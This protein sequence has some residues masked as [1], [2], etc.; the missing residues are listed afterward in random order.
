M[1]S[2]LNI[3]QDLHSNFALFVILLFFAHLWVVLSSAFFFSV[4]GCGVGGKKNLLPGYTSG[5]NYT[6]FPNNF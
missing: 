2:H 3:R 1:N 5:K 4:L 6:M